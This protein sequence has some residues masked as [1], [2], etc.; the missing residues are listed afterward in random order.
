MVEPK[1]GMEI[2]ITKLEHNFLESLIFPDK[3]T[4]NVRART[5]IKLIYKCAFS[6][7]M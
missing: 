1:S 2:L 3:V 5:S 4:L 7:F 6:I